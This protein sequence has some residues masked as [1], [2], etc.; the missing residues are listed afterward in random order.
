MRF[1]NAD[2]AEYFLK[3]HHTKIIVKPTGQEY[4]PWGEKKHHNTYE[5]YNGY[6]VSFSHNNK[7][8]SIDF[9]ICKYELLQEAKPNTYDILVYLQELIVYAESYEKYC[10]HF[11]L[12]DCDNTLIKYHERK[13]E[14]EDL[15]CILHHCIDEL[16]KFP[17]FLNFT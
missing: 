9:Y 4:E 14:R 17:D 6:F 11:R 16:L 8:F 3:R 1:S 10:N 15:M 2:L 5:C 7:S 12:N 13:K